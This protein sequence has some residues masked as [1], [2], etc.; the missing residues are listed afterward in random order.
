MTTRPKAEDVAWELI[1]EDFIVRSRDGWTGGDLHEAY[2]AI[3]RHFER[4]VR[5]EALEECATEASRW[6]DK[7]VLAESIYQAIRRKIEP[8]PKP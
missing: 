2:A 5:T 4:Q 7:S 3:L 1:D 6:R 8:E